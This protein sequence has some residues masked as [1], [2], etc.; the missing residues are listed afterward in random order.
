MNGIITK[1]GYKIVQ[2]EVEHD[3]MI[4]KD[5]KLVQTINVTRP[6][7]E[8]EAIDLFDFIRNTDTWKENQ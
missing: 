4:S 8:R 5:G 1:D 3:L 2:H 7:S 6:L